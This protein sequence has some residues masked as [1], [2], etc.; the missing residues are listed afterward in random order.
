M[1]PGA[2]PGTPGNRE[3]EEVS[4][5]SRGG[6]KPPFVGTRRGPKDPRNPRTHQ[7]SCV[8][9]G[10]GLLVSASWARRTGEGGRQ[11][12]CSRSVGERSEPAR[13]ALAAGKRGLPPPF[14]RANDAQVGPGRA[15]WGPDHLRGS[16][17]SK[18]SQIAH[19]NA[20]RT[21]G[22]YGEPSEIL[23]AQKLSQNAL[24]HVRK[25]FGV[26]GWN[27][28]PGGRG[29]NP[30]TGVSGASPWRALARAFRRTRRGRF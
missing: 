2:S 6:A 18:V 9:K 3:L 25:H 7:A 22:S 28:W 13:R 16:G 8:G 5:E 20:L 17:G 29:W 19:Q 11:A 15:D 23:S 21:P 12:P 27:P 26:Q 10:T 1:P 30:L 4:G 24:E 14:A